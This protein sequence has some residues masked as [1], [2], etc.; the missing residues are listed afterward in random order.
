Y[1]LRLNN[2]DTS[3]SFKTVVGSAQHPTPQF[4]STLTDFTTAGKLPSVT[5]PGETTSLRNPKGVIYLWFK[6]THGLSLA[7]R[8]EPGLFQKTYR[9]FSQDGIYVEQPEKL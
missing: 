1:D 6:N 2:A 4:N 7:G 3:M 5:L 8:P 9:A